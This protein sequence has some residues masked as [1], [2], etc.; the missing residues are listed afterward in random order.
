MKTWHNSRQ[1]KL[2]S[3]PREQGEKTRRE[4]NRGVRG[5]GWE[6]QHS[7]NR[8]S[9]KREQGNQREEIIQEI[10]KEDFP[11]MKD[12]KSFQVE[13]THQTSRF[14]SSHMI[15]KFQNPGGQKEN[16]TSPWRGK[17]GDFV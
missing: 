12:D 1:I 7:H 9:R 2:S 11:E 16:P 17:K 4:K 3:S 15:V 13:E 6:A 5:K 10:I 8:S 14:M